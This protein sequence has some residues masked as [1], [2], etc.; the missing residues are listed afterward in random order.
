[1]K[2]INLDKEYKYFIDTTTPK[3][4]TYNTNVFDEYY[5]V[6]EIEK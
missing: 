5:Y 2:D 4:I 1:M 3:T 6:T